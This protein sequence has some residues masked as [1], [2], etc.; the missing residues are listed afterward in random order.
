[1]SY[2]HWLTVPLDL[3]KFG[4]PAPTLPFL[5]A[6]YQTLVEA[7]TPAPNGAGLPKFGNFAPAL[8]LLTML[9]QTLV[10]ARPSSPHDPLPNFGKSGAISPERRGITKLW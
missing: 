8:P 2:P 9:Y 4:N 5:T 10:K 3:P 6:L 1:V 7:E